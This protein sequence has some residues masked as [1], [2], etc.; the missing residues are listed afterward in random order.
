MRYRTFEWT[1][2]DDEEVG[3]AISAATRLGVRWWGPTSKCCTAAYIFTLA[4]PADR[5]PGAVVEALCPACDLLRYTR[6]VCLEMIE[7]EMW[8]MT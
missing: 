7:R 3:Q 8:A 6:I 1:T 2:K 5:A 4:P